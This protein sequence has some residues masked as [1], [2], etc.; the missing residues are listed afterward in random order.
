MFI[1]ASFEWLRKVLKGW[2]LF[3]P[4][5]QDSQLRSRHPGALRRDAAP[6]FANVAYFTG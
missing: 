3:D 6:K 5:S 2:A 4:A 1:Y